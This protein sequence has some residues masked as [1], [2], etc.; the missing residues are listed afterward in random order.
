MKYF[1]DID[2]NLEDLDVLAAHEIVQAT[3]MAEL[4]REGFV[5]GWQERKYVLSTSS[6]L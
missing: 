4:G 6:R 5:N 3:A 1:Q 2:V